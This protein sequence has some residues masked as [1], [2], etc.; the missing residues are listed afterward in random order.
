M[1]AIDEGIEMKPA[2]GI[3]QI[4]EAGWADRRIWRDAGAGL[5]AL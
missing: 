1:R 2:G 5:A 3:K 4:I